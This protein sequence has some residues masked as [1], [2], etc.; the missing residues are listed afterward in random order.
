MSALLLTFAAIIVVPAYLI[1][2]WVKVPPHLKDVPGLSVWTVL[3]GLLSKKGFSVTLREHLGPV[4]EEHKMAKVFSGAM[5][6]VFVLDPEDCKHICLQTE[7]FPKFQPSEARR[8]T[9]GFKFFGQNIVNTIGDEWKKHRKVANPAFRRPWATKLFADSVYNLFDVIDENLGKAQDAHNLMQ[10]MTLDVL[11]QGLFDYDFHALQDHEGQRVTL[12]NDVMKGLFDPFRAFF[13]FLSKLPLPKNLRFKRLTEEFNALLYSILDDKQK[14]Y[15]KKVED[16]TFDERSTDLLTLMIKSTHE[17][18][19]LTNEELRSD[20]LVF[21]IAGHDTTANSLASA[22]CYLA[23]YPECQEK[24]RKEALAVLGDDPRTYPT[25][26][27]QAKELPYINAIMREA[28]RLVPPVPSLGARESTKPVE[29]KGKVFPAGTK[30]APH[31]YQMQRS[32]K[33]WSEPEVFKPERF[34]TE[35][36]V[37]SY[38]W[39]PF[40]GGSRQCI[41]MN[42]SLMEQRISLS[43]LLIKHRWVLP[44]DSVHS[45]GVLKI[46]S[47]GLLA[48]ESS[49]LC[50]ELLK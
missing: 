3:S 45:D 10:R 27:Q 43:M 41:G 36:N 23:M 30:F 25:L 17:D 18:Q 38:S 28:M 2:N 24:A 44:K 12:Y 49:E 46:C 39:L 42:F 16:G 37:T 4:L 26:E 31:I 1:Y 47:F 5:W 35:D 13:P 29:F 20:L 9:S 32:E 8:N 22:L 6:V 14:S 48:P 7:T 40:G 11:G 19:I 15:Q 21:F 34:L 33:Y 50:F